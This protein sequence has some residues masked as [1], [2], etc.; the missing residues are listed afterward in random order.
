MKYLARYRPTSTQTAAD[1][2]Q[3]IADRLG[4][5]DGVLTHYRAVRLDIARTANLMRRAFGIHLPS[6][7]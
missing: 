7:G 2:V 1:L 3:P 4:I 6:T 5:T